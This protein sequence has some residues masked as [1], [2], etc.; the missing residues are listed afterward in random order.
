MAEADALWQPRL[1]LD[2][3]EEVSD[4][5]E[6]ERPDSPSD[7]AGPGPAR[8]YAPLSTESDDESESEKERKDPER[9]VRKLLL[10]LSSR[11]MTD[12][13]METPEDFD[14]ER[15]KACLGTLEDRAFLASM[16][17]RFAR[18]DLKSD[19]DGV[20][21][22][23]RMHIHTVAVWKKWVYA[24]L[25][26]G[27]WV[28]L[29]PP[30]DTGV[31][32]LTKKGRLITYG[33]KQQ[34]DPNSVGGFLF[35][36]LM[37]FFALAL[38]I[39][40]IGA[41]QGSGAEIF[42]L[43]DE[44]NY[45]MACWITLIIA[46]L[47]FALYL[48][49]HRPRLDCG[50]S[51]RQ[52]FAV[53]DLCAAVYAREDYGGFCGRRKR[54]ELKLEFTKY[55]PDEVSD[56]ASVLQEKSR[57]AEEQAKGGGPK[58]LLGSRTATLLGVLGTLG[59]LYEYLAMLNFSVHLTPVCTTKRKGCSW[60]VDNDQFYGKKAYAEGALVPSDPE[61]ANCVDGQ[62]FCDYYWRH[63]DYCSPDQAEYQQASAAVECEQLPTLFNLLKE[64]PLY[65]SVAKSKDVK[66]VTPD[67]GIIPTVSS[68]RFFRGGDSVI[69]KGMEL[70]KVGSLT[71]VNAL[72]AKHLPIDFE[73]VETAC[74]SGPDGFVYVDLIREPEVEPL[75]QEDCEE[76]QQVC[77]AETWS[78][79]TN[80]WWPPN[81]WLD[82]RFER[83][84]CLY[85]SL[86]VLLSNGG[87]RVWR[88]VGGTDLEG[89]GEGC[90]GEPLLQSTAES[91]RACELLCEAETGCNY[92]FYGESDI[93]EDSGQR[94]NCILYAACPAVDV[95]E[96][97]KVF[98]QVQCGEALSRNYPNSAIRKVFVRP[99]TPGTPDADWRRCRD[100][101]LNATSWRSLCNGF[102]MESMPANLQHGQMVKAD[103]TCALF[104]P[105][106]FAMPAGWTRLPTHLNHTLGIPGVN[107]G[108]CFVRK[109]PLRP[110]RKRMT[111]A[112]SLR[113]FTDRMNCAGCFTR[114]V[115]SYYLEFPNLVNFVTQ[116][117]GV[118]AFVRMV[119]KANEA[120]P[121]AVAFS[122]KPEIVLGIARD[123]AN[124]AGFDDREA[125][126]LQFIRSCWDVHSRHRQRDAGA[127]D[128]WED[129]EDDSAASSAK[130]TTGLT[131]R[132]NLSVEPVECQ[133]YDTYD[134]VDSSRQHCYVDK[135]LLGM[136]PGEKVAAVWNETQRHSLWSFL[137]FVF[138]YGFGIALLEWLL[139]DLM[140]ARAARA[141][142]YLVVPGSLLAYV[143]FKL[144]SEL[145]CLCVT[146]NTG[147]VIQLS[148]TPPT[149]LGFVCPHFF[150]GTDLR[151]DMFV[152][153]KA[154]Y[155][156]LDMP[157]K[158]IW[159]DWI[160]AWRRDPWRRGTVSVRGEHGLLQVRRTNGEAVVAYRALSEMIE[161][162]KTQGLRACCLGTAEIFGITAIDD[163][164][165][166]D[167]GLIWERKLNCVGH[168]TD[169]FDYTSL[170]VITDSRLHVARA[171]CP[172]P[173][174]L[175]GLLLGPLTFGFRC[176]HIQEWL[177]HHAGLTISSLA[178][179]SLESYATTRSRA[180][181]FWPG[182]GPPIDGFGFVFMP[183]FTQIY[184]AALSV[185]QK[186]YGLKVKA[187]VQD[188]A[189]RLCARS[190]FLR[191][192]TSAQHSLP[193]G[194]RVVMVE[195]AS[196][197]EIELDDECWS[198][199][200]GCLL[201]EGS[202]VTLEAVD[203]QW[204][205][206]SDEPWVSQLRAIMDIV[207]GKGAEI[208]GDVA[209]SDD[210]WDV[211]EDPPPAE[212]PGCCK[213]IGAH[214]F[215]PD[216]MGLH[217]LPQ[218]SFG[219]D[220]SDS[221]NATK[222]GLV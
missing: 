185:S 156:Q 145:Q 58:H 165:L 54:G 214:V 147:R 184:P 155:V 78:P 200:E 30:D 178:H 28:F 148:R 89:F 90:H 62:R 50:S 121:M 95:P 161:A 107:R 168:F 207:L 129:M 117:I 57:A 211:L 158:P 186:P 116:L 198:A 42:S 219:D 21:A 38:A 144:R 152:V 140:Q 173:L 36:A 210:T 19:G 213:K 8:T 46:A 9:G 143:Y 35:Q 162:K 33:K 104:G 128:F 16:V 188:P 204:S 14:E 169:P 94:Y 151:L 138:L 22:A 3:Y 191:V 105:S 154:V 208:T 13:D 66:Y 67:S 136:A 77:L 217:S 53:S 111:V 216:M 56:S 88:D 124:P 122:G 159:A 12:A 39:T 170:M 196:G 194:A 120:A 160:R 190:G 70:R 221:S 218:F 91:L 123:P 99:H 32:I 206:V 84:L 47:L 69:P 37:L 146:T 6:P 199:P 177:G 25:T 174:S 23:I 205:T 49:S 101:C 126:Y 59:A 83:A 80:G 189:I 171:R 201:E 109:L 131:H 76:L 97:D 60:K 164:L 73:Q 52:H 93:I 61:S 64:V 2:D 187:T 20:E 48:F 10:D 212:N 180:P 26:C 119:R 113:V 24:I 203:H 100:A 5:P 215:G 75:F 34:A 81:R 179:S 197:E 222:D 103:F 115:S 110:D 17:H 157:L 135:R 112:G 133:D 71:E 202:R 139:P 118:I 125:A 74:H 192:K 92:A 1:F 31:L 114:G 86:P 166:P 153:G 63:S 40:L 141:F 98:R 106:E 181:P 172:K 41:A 108:S 142:L 82:L 150:G 167:E 43:M 175:R 27:A 87:H 79:E 15:S 132:D 29:R 176:M 195:D 44:V 149:G 137:V 55:Y 134:L 193:K 85:D 220:D 11:L 68:P 18:D 4:G 130:A 127:K 163:L 183:K 51:Y 96:S 45:Q 102:A 65:A 209:N 182:L 72:L 7:R